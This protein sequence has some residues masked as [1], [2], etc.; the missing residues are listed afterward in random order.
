MEKM[1]R[2]EEG[3]RWRGKEV[4]GRKREVEGERRREGE[5]EGGKEGKTNE[6]TKH[7]HLYL[8]RGASTN[9]QMQHLLIHRP[10]Y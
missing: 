8:M 7:Q 2:E 5:T 6:S 3:R 9:I 1:V 4:E 10:R